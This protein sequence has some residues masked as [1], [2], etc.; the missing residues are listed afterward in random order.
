MKSIELFTGAGGLALGTHNAGF[1]HEVCIEW[2]EDACNTLRRN[3]RDKVVRGIDRWN[4]YQADLSAFSFSE[5]SG[6]EMVAGGVPCQPFSLGGKHRGMN[7][8]R[9]MFPH[10][11]R[12]IDTLRPR[13]FIV[14]NVKGLLRESFRPYFEYVRLQLTYP[15][16]RLNKDETWEEHHKR[17]VDF[18]GSGAVKGL[19]YK[20]HPKLLNAADFGVAQT[21]E[22]VFV[23]GFRSDI[24]QD[25]HFPNPTHSEIAL[26]RDQ[27]ITGDYWSNHKISMPRRTSMPSQAMRARAALPQV[28][29]VKRWR[30]VRD[31]IY[32]DLTEPTNQGHL[33]FPD[34]LLIEGARAY[35][36]HTGSPIDRPAKTLKAGVHGVPGGENMV[37]FPNGKVRYFSV[38]EAKRIQT[39][40]R[41]WSFS[42]AWSEVMRQLGNAVPVALA[43]VVARSVAEHLRASAEFPKPQCNS[44]TAGA[45]RSAPA[46]GA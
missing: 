22:R 27:F 36:G 3:A 44:K 19:V 14:E 41:D 13:A 34:H 2:D 16:V 24:P 7:D 29:S 9:N 8:E 11:V 5:L 39:F 43:E 32:D 26:I 1:E 46:S 17:L 12:A 28:P 35:K 38:Q 20:V 40:P 37:A 15:E 6:I 42:G 10:F 21:R 25:W 33:R 18:D 45:A 4:V 23:V 31:E 30:T